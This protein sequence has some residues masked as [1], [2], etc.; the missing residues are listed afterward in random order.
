MDLFVKMFLDDFPLFFG[1]LGWELLIVC[2]EALRLLSE[3]YKWSLL[4]FRI[5][6]L[7]SSEGV[8]DSL[9]LLLLILLL[10]KSIERS[11]SL[12]FLEVSSSLKYYASFSWALQS[13]YSFKN[14]EVSLS[15]AY[16]RDPKVLESPKS[17][18]SL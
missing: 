3:P 14:S 1:I 5:R 2:W 11:L 7:R 18:S 12:F 16:L 10:L 9:P 8:P 15:F 4:W 6:A 17:I 13:L